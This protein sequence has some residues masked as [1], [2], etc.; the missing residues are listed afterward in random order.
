VP[1]EL[2]ETLDHIKDEVLRIGSDFKSAVDRHR[3]EIDA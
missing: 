2:S 3:D 1:P